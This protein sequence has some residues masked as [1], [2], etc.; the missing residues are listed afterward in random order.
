MDASYGTL[1]QGIDASGL[2]SKYLL[3]MELRFDAILY[4]KLGNENSYAGNI[5]CSHGPHLPRRPQVPHT[6]FR[7]LTLFCLG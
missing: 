6:C 2:L 4:S 7:R 5:K 1:S 3:T